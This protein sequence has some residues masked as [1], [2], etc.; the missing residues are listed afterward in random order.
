MRGPR[1]AAWVHETRSWRRPWWA[2][3]GAHA[4]RQRA[5]IV[6]RC[7]W[8]ETAAVAAVVAL[9]PAPP[10]P[11]TAPTLQDANQCYSHLIKS[12]INES[13]RTRRVLSAADRWSVRVNGV[14][15]RFVPF[16]LC[17]TTV[18][19]CIEN[20]SRWGLRY[21]FKENTLL[22]TVLHA[23]FKA[24]IVVIPV[25]EIYGNTGAFNRRGKKQI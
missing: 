9:A 5:P 12:G 25:L 7:R 19:C 14:S 17:C 2:L 22:N 6:R 16:I 4:Q 10:H 20:S 13:Y 23:R 15:S 3:R 11:T 8:P 18:Y 21:G 24:I 1:L